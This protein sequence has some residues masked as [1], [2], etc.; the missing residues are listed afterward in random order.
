MW[1]LWLEI[2]FM[3]IINC[4]QCENSGSSIAPHLLLFYLIIL[5]AALQ[6]SDVYRAESCLLGEFSVSTVQSACRLSLLF[7]GSP[8]Y[9]HVGWALQTFGSVGSTDGAELWWAYHTVKG[10]KLDQDSSGSVRGR[11]TYSFG[12]FMWLV[13]FCLYYEMKPIE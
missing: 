11:G 10:Q 4:L 2:T 1:R 8:Q 5:M 12:C 6:G 3:F 9:S 7:S 13:S